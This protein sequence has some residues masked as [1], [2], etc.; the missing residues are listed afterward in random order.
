MVHDN[1]TP[2]GYRTVTP[3]LTVKDAEK[4]IRFLKTVFDAEELNRSTNAEGRMVHAEVRIGDAIVEISE[5]T[6]RLLPVRLRTACFLLP[7]A[8]DYK[9]C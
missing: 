4:M 5:G 8:E 7:K 6:D 1:Y 2:H 3:Y 9:R